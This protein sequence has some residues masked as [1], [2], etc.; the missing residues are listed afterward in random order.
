MRAS[1]Y[2]WRI[3]WPIFSLEPGLGGV[4]VNAVRRGESTVAEGI[5][6]RGIGK[7]SMDAAV[8]EVL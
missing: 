8:F 7:G 5:V 6:G 4:G 3:N 1:V 2:P